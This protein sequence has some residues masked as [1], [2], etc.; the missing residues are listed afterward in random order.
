[1]RSR[2]VLLDDRIRVVGVTGSRNLRGSEIEDVAFGRTPYGLVLSFVVSHARPVMAW[3][4]SKGYR[5]T[6]GDPVEMM[7]RIQERARSEGGL[8]N[9][10]PCP[11]LEP[12]TLEVLTTLPAGVRFDGPGVVP[13]V[14]RIL[15]GLL[16]SMAAFFVVAGAAQA[17][18]P[19][20]YPWLLLVPVFGFFVFGLLPVPFVARRYRP[21]LRESVATTANWMGVQE[22]S[23][24]KGMSLEGLRGIG[25]CRSV[26]ATSVFALP[27]TMEKLIL[28]DAEG[29]RLEVDRPRLTAE[30]KVVLQAH[31]A[32]AT[33]TESA[34]RALPK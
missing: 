21:L 20:T 18:L 27:R 28:V 25:I 9:P 15:P 19:Q 5:P 16:L 31:A 22:R 12:K 17:A 24:W 33:V 4:V 7:E 32:N 1:L 14:K 13:V 29:H 8:P 3:G 11:S 23:G 6:S 30:A 10:D 2:I 34:A 26:I